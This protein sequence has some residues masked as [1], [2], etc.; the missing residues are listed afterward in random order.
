MGRFAIAVKLGLAIAL[1]VG[2]GIYGVGRTTKTAEDV[3]P[4]IGQWHLAAG[5]P[6]AGDGPAVAGG[7]DTKAD[8][9]DEAR[10][11][12][13]GYVEGSKAA[14]AM[15]GVIKND[16]ARVA[17]GANL[18][19][20]GHASE[21]RLIAADGTLLHTWSLARADAFPQLD[22]FAAEADADRLYWRWVG[23]RGDGSIIA[24]FEGAGLVALD[25]DSKLLWASQGFNHHDVDIAPDGTIYA[26]GRTRRTIDSI[27]A[28]PVIDDV[29][30]TLSADGK[31]TRSISMLSALTPELLA[32]IP[33]QPVTG[34]DGNPGD[35][36]LHTNAVRYLDGSQTALWPEFTRGRLL[37]SIRELDALVVIDPVSAKVVWTMTDVF[38]KQHD[39]ELLANGRILLFDNVGA[40]TRSRI[41]E[42]QP[43]RPPTVVFDGGGRPFFSKTCGAAQRLPNGNLLVTESETGR[44]IEVTPRGDTV[45]EFWNPYRAGKDGKYIA[46]LFEMQ[47]VAP[48]LARLVTDRATRSR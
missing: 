41:L 23:L 13:L 19:V 18:Y 1:L 11:L 10:L 45:W 43:G 4:K 46:A 28:T 42:L 14:P 9:G 40:G 3:W 21:A 30:E 47:R 6:G 44:A 2:M 16:S 36:V 22:G 31:L 17:P 27:R 25:R 38:R 5:G 37:V 29:I 39:P 20:S 26:L 12:A 33:K 35:D 32:R 15:S 8:S 48:E 24:V 7:V 34:I